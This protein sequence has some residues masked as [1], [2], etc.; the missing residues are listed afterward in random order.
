[1]NSEPPPQ[2]SSRQLTQQ[3]LTLEP[4]DARHLATLCGHLDSHLRQIE[5]R[6]GIRIS[7]RGNQFQLSGPP[8]NV[9]TAERLLIHLYAEV[10]QGVG[11]TEAP[12]G[13]LAHW[14]RIRDR[15]IDN[16]QLVVPTTWNGSPRD[17]TGRRSAFEESLIGTPVAD[18]GSAW[19]ANV[20]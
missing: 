17:A 7:A 16:Y 11:L 1:M 10:C 13:A 2:P 9:A 18:F 14:I 15:K 4:D 3:S 20:E 12:R 19:A 6:L 8:V 5:Q